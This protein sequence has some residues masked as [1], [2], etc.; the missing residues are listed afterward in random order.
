MENQEKTWIVYGHCYDATPP[1][2]YKPGYIKLPELESGLG[3]RKREDGA[4]KDPPGIVPEYFGV[5]VDSKLAVKL[6]KNGLIKKEGLTKKLKGLDLETKNFID[7]LVDLS[8]GITFDKTVMLKILSQPNCE[9]L[10]AYLCAR[11]ENETTPHLSLVMV[12][13]DMNGF[14]LNYDLNTTI[15]DDE[16]PNQS[17]LVEYGYPPG[18]NTP[19]VINKDKDEHYVLLRLAEKYKDTNTPEPTE[20]TQEVI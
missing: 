13:V 6:I 18:G 15:K 8:Y 11:N 5:P 20:T 12:G 4:K 14:D 19:P 17:L 16:I 7:N 10:R 3:M 1:K 9:G 2:N